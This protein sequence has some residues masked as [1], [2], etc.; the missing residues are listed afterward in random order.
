[1]YVL[2]LHICM[3]SAMRRRES[4]LRF[5]LGR[6]QVPGSILDTPMVRKPIGST[7]EVHT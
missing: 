5:F 1:M 6:R 4:T 3:P 2:D 7:G